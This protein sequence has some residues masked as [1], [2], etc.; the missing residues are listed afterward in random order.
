MATGSFQSVT[1]NSTSNAYPSTDL[2]AWFQ[3]SPGAYAGTFSANAWS[4]DDGVQHYITGYIGMSGSASLSTMTNTN[5]PTT[6]SASLVV[7]TQNTNQYL[8]IYWGYDS[9]SS[10]TNYYPSYC[11]L[12]LQIEGQVLPGS[13]LQFAGWSIG[14]G[15]SNLPTG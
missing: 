1:I 5:S 8:V 9:D 7:P 15:T 2:Y 13:N 4:T 14:N 11:Q 3:V 6:T 12:T 10:G